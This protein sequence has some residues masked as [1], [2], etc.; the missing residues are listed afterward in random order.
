MI[1]LKLL[2][3]TFLVG[4][5][6]TPNIAVDEFAHAAPFATKHQVAQAN[7]SDEVLLGVCNVEVGNVLRTLLLG[8]SA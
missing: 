8:P 7:D 3:Q 5:D 6:A 4:I 1:T 2:H